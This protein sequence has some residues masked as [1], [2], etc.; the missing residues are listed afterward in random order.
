M[1]NKKTFYDRP[2]QMRY[3]TRLDSTHQHGWRVR[4]GQST[5]KLVSKFF[6]DFKYRD[7]KQSLKAA[8]RF[9]NRIAATLFGN[10]AL[11]VMRR[12]HYGLQVP[13]VPGRVHHKKFFSYKT[14]RNGRR[15]WEDHYGGLRAGSCSVQGRGL[16]G[17]SASQGRGRYHPGEWD[18]SRLL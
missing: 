14:D 2:A 7:E 3:I 6:S 4:M 13:F 9:R 10:R 17:G 18:G 15:D 16:A 11:R 1:K 12:Y 8:Q 5:E